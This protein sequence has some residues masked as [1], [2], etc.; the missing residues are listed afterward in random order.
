MIKLQ[1]HYKLIIIWHNLQ[2]FLFIQTCDLKFK[3]SLLK[4]CWVGVFWIKVEVAKKKTIPTEVFCQIFWNEIK[5][6]IINLK[7]INL[8]L[9]YIH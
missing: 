3:C 8:I 4:G 5:P 9:D 1:L 6:I 2:T 7:F